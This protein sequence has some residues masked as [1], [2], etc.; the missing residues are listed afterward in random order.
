MFVGHYGVALASKPIRTSVHPL[1]R[2]S[3]ATTA[4]AV[5][6]VLALVVAWVERIATVR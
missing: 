2:T 3:M 4:L 5:Y 6:V 1:R